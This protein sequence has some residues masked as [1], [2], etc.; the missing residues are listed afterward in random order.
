MK[1]FVELSCFTIYDEGYNLTLVVTIKVGVMDLTFRIKDDV[2][3]KVLE[4]FAAP[5]K[6]NKLNLELDGLFCP[7]VR[8]DGK[9]VYLPMEEQE[10][11]DAFGVKK[12]N[13][14]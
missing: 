10:A 2:R 8:L 3:L 1:R 5:N 7:S 11:M 13:S 6:T 9:H 14:I 4:F 12:V